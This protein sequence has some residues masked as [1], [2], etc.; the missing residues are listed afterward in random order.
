MSSQETGPRDTGDPCLSRS[1]P[2]INLTDN[3]FDRH[4][5]TI[6]VTLATLEH[7]T[8]PTFHSLLSY[9]P[10]DDLYI[11][12]VTSCILFMRCSSHII[13]SNK[14][15]NRK[16]S[17]LFNPYPTHT[18]SEDELYRHFECSLVQRKLLYQKTCCMF[19]EVKR[20]ANYESEQ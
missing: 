13:S 9:L 7:I 5:A 18:D 12:H 11:M 17:V 3:E 6:H 2:K 20:L 4:M 8:D 1:Q 19:L 15:E 10:N 16:A 14:S